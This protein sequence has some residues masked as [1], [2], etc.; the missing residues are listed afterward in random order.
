[1]QFRLSLLRT[2]LVLGHNTSKNPE[3][4]YN[5]PATSYGEETIT[6]TNLL[7]IRR[8]HPNRVKVLTFTKQK[9]SHVTGADWEWHFIG[10]RRSLKLRVQA[11]RVTMKGSI[12][13]LDGQAKKAPSPQID[14]LISSAKSNNFKPVYCFYCAEKDRNIWNTAAISGKYKGF[15]TGC[16]IADARLVKSMSPLP[17]KLADVEAITIPWHYFCAGG[18]YSYKMDEDD[19]DPTTQNFELKIH[20][21]NSVDLP[22]APHRPFA[23]RFPTVHDLNT[24]SWRDFD[25]EGIHFAD[26]GAFESEVRPEEF[27]ERGIRRIVKVDV[28]EPDSLP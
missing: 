18:G 23:A 19:H 6:E 25:Q 12:R 20:R 17:K 27:R 2:L 22:D 24:E 26:E 15:E 21:L 7:D 4:A 28:R 13:K 1:M 14:L 10:S 16:L 8:R 3:Y 9:E 11:K 5:Y